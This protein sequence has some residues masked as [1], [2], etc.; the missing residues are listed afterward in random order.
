MLAKTDKKNILSLAFL[1]TAGET[2]MTNKADVIVIGAGVSG[3]AAAYDLIKAGKKVIVLEGRDRIGGRQWT[4]RTWKNIPMD[5]GAS[6]IHGIKKNP[7]TKLAEE[8]NMKMAVTSEDNAVLYD[9]NGSEVSDEDFEKMEYTLNKV[10]K[11]LY[12]E[13]KSVKKDLSLADM[14]EKYMK[15]NNFSEKEKKNMRF[16]AYS[17]I[18]ND[19]A[20]DCSDLSFLNWDEDDEFDGEEVIFPDG[21]DVM[22]ANLAKAMDIRLKNIVN[23]ISYNERGVTVRTDK[24]TYSADSAVLSVPLGVLKK[25]KIQFEPALPED[26]QKSIDRLKMGILDKLYLKFNEAF[27]PKEPEWILYMGEEKGD[28]YEFLN[29]Y[30]Y[31]DKPIL[32]LFNSGDDAQR[33]EDIPDE[34]FVQETMKVLRKLFDKDA[35]NPIEILRTNWGKDEF[36]YGSYSHIPPGAESEDYDTL[37][38]P[39]EDVLFFAGEAT[40]SEYPGTIHGALI[41]GRRAAEE[42]LD[43]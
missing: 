23:K 26:K 36:S 8:F 34:K 2:D 9:E 21:Y 20:A 27:W 42:I 40:S 37:A 22:S 11:A 10:L 18:E 24:D 4:D 41:S 17:A 3:L 16:C 12:K 7:V 25:G 39:V 38:E 19:Y 15:E 35:P 33:K 31:T 29:I 13:R 32:L 5:M 28:W 43:L 14:L 1:Q 30:H 6:W